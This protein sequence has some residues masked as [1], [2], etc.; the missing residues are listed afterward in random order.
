[1][2]IVY[3]KNSSDINLSIFKY[4]DFLIFSIFFILFIKVII[5]TFFK[6][7]DNCE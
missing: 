2:S 5:S 6:I 7:E 3:M 1:M 4:L